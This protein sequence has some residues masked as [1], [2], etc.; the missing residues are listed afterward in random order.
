[1]IP[2]ETTYHARVAIV[3]TFHRM[4]SQ[5]GAVPG[6]QRMVP[7]SSPWRW[8]RPTMVGSQVAG[9]RKWPEFNVAG[10]ALL[11]LPV[12]FFFSILVR[13]HTLSLAWS[14]YFFRGDADLF[15]LSLFCLYLKRGCRLLTVNGLGMIPPQLFQMICSR[16]PAPSSRA[17]PMPGFRPECR[18]DW[19]HLP[20]YYMRCLRLNQLSSQFNNNHK[21]IDLPIRER[22]TLR[23]VGLQWN[24]P[25]IFSHFILAN[26]SIENNTSPAKLSTHVTHKRRCGALSFPFFG[27]EAGRRWCTQI[28]DAEHQTARSGVQ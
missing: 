24:R 16:R 25:S 10:R 27:T 23:K 20:T 13:G 8:R 6:S 22:F 12:C 19:R 3:L 11:P 4:D 21:A 1:M 5:L 14:H 18:L 28:T 17:T 7:F 2:W 15:F 9:C 26:V